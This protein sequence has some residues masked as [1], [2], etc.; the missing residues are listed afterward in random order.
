[1]CYKV[2]AMDEQQR[3]EDHLRVIRNLMERATIYRAIS[4]PTALIGGALGTIVSIFLLWNL[5]GPD[6]IGLGL[7]NRGLTARPFILLWLLVLL[8]TLCANTWFIFRKSRREGTSLFTPS[9]KLTIVSALPALFIVSIFTALFWSYDETEDALPLLVNI[10]IICYGL[11]LLAT[12]PFAPRSL[13]VLGWVVLGTGGFLLAFASLIF[14]FDPAMRAILAMGLT[15]GLYH[16]A[17]A[18]LTWP[19]KS[20]DK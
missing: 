18:A 14:R 6:R 10:W 9:L 3:A 1:L 4:A 12:S 7:A 19:A 5:A 13:V 15:F 11:L 2:I 17:Y 20:R 8:V 16:L